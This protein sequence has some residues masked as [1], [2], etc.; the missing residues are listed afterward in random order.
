MA[1]NTVKHAQRGATQPPSHPAIPITQ[2]ALVVGLT[3]VQGIA[4]AVAAIFPKWSGVSMFVIIASALALVGVVFWWAWSVTRHSDTIPIKI[5]QWAFSIS[6]AFLALLLCVTIT[7]WINNAPLSDL[8]FNET[9]V[10]VWSLTISPKAFV[11]K[12]ELRIHFDGHGNSRN[13]YFDDILRGYVHTSTVNINN[14]APAGAPATE[15]QHFSQTYIMIL[16]AHPVNITNTDQIQITFNKDTS[17]DIRI[18]DF[19]S[20]W[21]VIYVLG[22]IPEGDLDIFVRGDPLAVPN[23]P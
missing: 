11:N 15:P 5:R 20:Y 13:T 8:I 3:L 7:L 21:I 1:R 6:S 23:I 19:G 22:Q 17:P 16:F 4:Q 9:P 18:S 2:S 10:G 12:A 14:F